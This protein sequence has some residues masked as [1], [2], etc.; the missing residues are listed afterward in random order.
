M[1][2]G[3]LTLAV[4]AAGPAFIGGAMG[5]HL[6]SMYG[7]AAVASWRPGLFPPRATLGAGLAIML[8]GAGAVFAGFSIASVTIGLVA[9]GVGWGAVN[10]A[11]L[12]LLHDAA[13]PSR[14]AMAQHD[15]CLLGA[16]AAGALLF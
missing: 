8:A 11:A 7:P 12:R 16:A 6:F 5:W 15:L 1:L 9:I 14:T 2:H 13:R 4:C 10:V 3:P